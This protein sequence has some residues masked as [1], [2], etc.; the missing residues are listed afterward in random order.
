MA[1]ALHVLYIEDDPQMVRLVSEAFSECS[2][3]TQVHGVT[4]WTEAQAFLTGAEPYPDASAPGLVLLDKELGTESG[5]DLIL[6]LRDHLAA[7]T[8]IVIFTGAYEQADVDLAYARGANA[9]IQ[10][11]DNFD[12]L[13]TFAKGAATLW[14][15]T[16]ADVTS[17]SSSQQPRHP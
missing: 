5:L 7:A 1:E 2:I 4:T 13:V 8:P 14:Q 17:E 10:K 11:P 15:R 3:L 6:P 9:Y 16:A 12:A